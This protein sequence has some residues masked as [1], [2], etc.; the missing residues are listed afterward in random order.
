VGF[1]APVQPGWYYF[2]H[3]V[4]RSGPVS[5]S[6]LLRLANVG[7]IRPGSMVWKDGYSDWASAKSIRGLFP[8][9]VATFVEVDW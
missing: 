4:P 5:N 8:E 1:N 6:E 9:P 2:D 3:D 7:T